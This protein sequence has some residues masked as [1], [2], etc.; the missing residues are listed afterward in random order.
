MQTMYEG[1]FIY[2]FFLVVQWGIII[3]IYYTC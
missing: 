3:L 2:E 1:I